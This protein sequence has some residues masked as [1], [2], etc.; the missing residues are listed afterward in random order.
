MTARSSRLPAISPDE[1][2]RHVR[3]VQRAIEQEGWSSQLRRALA[4]RCGV[5]PTDVDRY[6]AEVEVR[7]R[8]RADWY[9][10]QDDDVARAELLDRLRSYQRSA[11]KAEHW[12]SVGQMMALE[13]RLRGFDQIKVRVQVRGAV[14]VSAFPPAVLEALASGAD[15]DEI[16]RIVDGPALRALPSPGGRR[17]G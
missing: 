7:L 4:D 13:A 16:G 12:G 8:A 5:K 2:E 9:S 11:A 15:D 10:E 17:G 3:L 1:R 6:R 14:D